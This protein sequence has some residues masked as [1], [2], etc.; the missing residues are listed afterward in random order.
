MNRSVLVEMKGGRW[1][2]DD[3]KSR[4][5]SGCR[6]CRKGLFQHVPPTVEEWM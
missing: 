3:M 4:G 1:T 2:F 5:A 6:E